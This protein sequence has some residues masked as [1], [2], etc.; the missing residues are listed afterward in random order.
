MAEKT[1]FIMATRK[2]RKGET[3]TGTERHRETGRE[4]ETDI[5]TEKVS[6]RERSLGPEIAI[7]SIILMTYFIL[8]GPTS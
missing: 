2:Q 3:E 8:L 6:Q 7:K 1:A 4:I 5:E